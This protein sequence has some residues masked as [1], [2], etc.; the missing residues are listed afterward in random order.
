MIEAWMESLRGVVEEQ[1]A[2]S[3]WTAYPTVFAA[4]VLVSLT[5]CVYPVIPILVGFVGGQAKGNRK[6]SFLLSLAYILGM[7]IVYSALGAFAA[8]SG[9]MFGEVQSNPWFQIV[10]A[11]VII[12]CGLAMLGVVKIPVP[13]FLSRGSGT[14][15]GIVGALAMGTA[16]GFIAA[17]CTAA[18]LF[19]ILTYVAS[20]QSI[21]LGVT[22]LF[23]FS[24]GMGVLL[25]ILGT[26]VGL[27]TSIPRA[28][29]WMV[30]IEKAFGFAMILLGEYFLIKGG[31]LMAIGSMW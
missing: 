3:A 13:G 24:L 10:V 11:N 16:S 14:R 27:L 23:S 7:A 25:V 9:R 6:Q 4:G 26:F 22:L 12:F 2:G 21:F 15:P 8:L 31:S 28:G 30:G 18:I 20:K 19:A 17:P 5:P 29:K 1:L